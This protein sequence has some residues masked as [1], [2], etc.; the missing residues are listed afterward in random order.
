MSEKLPWFKFYASDWQTDENILFMGFFERGIYLEL[1]LRNWVEG[2]IPSCPSKCLIL[3]KRLLAT[4]EKAD[5][6]RIE[7]AL[8]KILPLFYQPPEMPGRLV[9][10]KLTEQRQ[11]MMEISQKRATSGSLGGRAVTKKDV[12]TAGKQMLSKPQAN[13]SQQNRTEQNRIIKEKYKKESAEKEEAVEGPPSLQEVKTAFDMQGGSEQMAI[14][15]FA[16]HEQLNWL[17][18][19]G[20]PNK[21]WRSAVK[22]YILNWQSNTA[23][24][25]KPVSRAGDVWV[26]PRY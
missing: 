22:S 14:S 25:S 2:S 18:A 21:N 12:K 10:L 4:D 23:A 13:A 19:H 6:S 26:D 20:R 7:K 9:H 1:L 8:Q 24:K 3:L 15:F 5:D 17:N 16:K 11:K